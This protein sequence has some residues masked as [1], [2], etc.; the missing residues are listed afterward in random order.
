MAGQG[1]R[2][3]AIYGNPVGKTESCEVLADSRI[4][5]VTM[6]STSSIP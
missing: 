4:N 5:N 6:G 3:A 1:T 2:L